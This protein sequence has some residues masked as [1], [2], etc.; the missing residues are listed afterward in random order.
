MILEFCKSV[1]LAGIEFDAII[2]FCANFVDNGFDHAFGT[3]HICEWQIEEITDFMIDG[4]IAQVCSDN[5]K[6]SLWLKSNRKRIK[7]AIKRAVSQVRREIASLDLDATA[8]NDELLEACGDAPD[9]RRDE[10]DYRE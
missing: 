8:S 10:D 4:S 7:K 2:E 9:Y 5:C 1:E 3:R 6:S